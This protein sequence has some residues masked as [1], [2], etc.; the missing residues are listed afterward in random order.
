MRTMRNVDP[1]YDEDEDDDEVVAR[2]RARLAFKLARDI[3]TK[4][5]PRRFGRDVDISVE[6]DLL[7]EAR[8]LVR[9]SNYPTKSKNEV[10]REVNRLWADG[11]FGY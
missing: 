1:D 9:E 4:R 10:M 11:D 7:T 8:K 6:R 5:N 3:L 2:N